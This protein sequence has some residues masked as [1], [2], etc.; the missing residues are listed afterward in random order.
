MTEEL[1]VD[2]PDT[3]EVVEFK[4]AVVLVVVEKQ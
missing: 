1:V 3:R 4:T 2:H